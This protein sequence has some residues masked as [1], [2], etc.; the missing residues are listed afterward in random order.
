MQK[1]KGPSEQEKLPSARAAAQ[2]RR[3][4]EFRDMMG[5]SPLKPP[6]VVRPAEGG[7]GA[8]SRKT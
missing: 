5:V 2:E 6:R 3:E 8:K 7:D 1:P 4:A